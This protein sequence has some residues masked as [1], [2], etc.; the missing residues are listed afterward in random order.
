MSNKRKVR[1]TPTHAALP[2]ESVW[3]K[4]VVQILG[5]GLVVSLVAIVMFSQPEARG[6]PDGTQAVAIASADHVSGTVY[7]NNEV[8]AGGAMDS[9]WQNCGFY[10]GQ[11]R[12]EN[13][14]HSLEHGAVWV[15]YGAGLAS[16]DVASLRRFVSRSEKVVVS[17]V[18]LQGAPIIVS[19]WGRQLQI[20]DPSDAR[21]DQ[22]V[23]EF[24]GAPSAPERGGRCNG[25][26]GQPQF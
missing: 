1:Q 21:L 22:F 15:T 12:A 4:R 9:I 6:V 8:P 5:V 20:N 3:P 11:V 10:D 24:T 17:A 25:G 14:V 16:D 2:G 13:V 26:V 18:P 7:A 19:A 23:N